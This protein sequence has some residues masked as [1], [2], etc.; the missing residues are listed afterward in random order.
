MARAD[1]QYQL[2]G[3]Y[4]R[5]LDLWRKRGA[6]D[7]AAYGAQFVVN[8]L[9]PIAVGPSLRDHFISILV[10]VWIAIANVFLQEESNWKLSNFKTGWSEV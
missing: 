6:W 3:V 1:L 5:T 9:M 4:E 8:V 10:L 2:S 7:R